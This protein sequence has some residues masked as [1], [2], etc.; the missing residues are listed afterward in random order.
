MTS[1]PH[2]LETA[3]GDGPEPARLQRQAALIDPLTERLLRDAG[4][5]TGMHVLELGSGTGD[6]SMLAAELVGPGGRVV[7]LER[8][9]DATEIA[10]ARM[11]DAGIDHVAFVQGDIAQLDLD[12]SFDAV[13]GRL[14]LMYPPDPAA[15]LA[16][17]CRP[18]RPGG[19]VVMHEIVSRTR[20]AAPD[21][22]LFAEVARV[23]AAAFEAVGAA[24]DL[25]ERLPAV[26]RE[27]G[28]PDPEL[29]YERVAGGGRR[30]A[31]ITDWCAD[32]LAGLAPVIE[33]AGIAGVG[34][35]GLDTLSERLQAELAQ[36]GGIAMMAPMVGAFSRV[37]GG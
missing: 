6:V 5:T 22:P 36:T 21:S 28:L 35:L 32:V 9:A 15:V 29:R 10:R 11:W 26:F 34:E 1:N 7:G 20:L 23:A 24:T 27:A 18:L 25:G 19:V 4:I 3:A 31:A 2:S 8:D 30:A 17:A 12:G 33:H 16:R 13:V 14:I 37:A